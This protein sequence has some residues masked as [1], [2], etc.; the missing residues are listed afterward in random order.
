MSL[1]GTSQLLRNVF[2][3]GAMVVPSLP[4][5]LLTVAPQLVPLLQNQPAQC[6]ITAMPWNI[7]S[8]REDDRLVGGGELGETQR[9]ARQLT[10]TRSGSKKPGPRP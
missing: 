1:S 10:V 6:L 8:M 3:G 9:V 4:D 2:P 7:L 5:T